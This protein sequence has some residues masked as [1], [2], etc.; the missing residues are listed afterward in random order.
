MRWKYIRNGINRICKKFRR[1]HREARYHES[2][3]IKVSD[4]EF[5]KAFQSIYRCSRNDAKKALLS[6]REN[7]KPT[8]SN[9][10][11]D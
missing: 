11:T 7:S 9:H 2:N 8:T 10:N 1:G 3:E 6:I 4:E 5:L